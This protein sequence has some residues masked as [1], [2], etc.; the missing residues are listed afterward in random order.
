MLRYSEHLSFGDQ[1]EPVFVA[2]N[3]LRPDAPG[4]G[5]VDD[6]IGLCQHAM[7]FESC[8]MRQIIGGIACHFSG[9]Q[10]GAPNMFGGPAQFK[11]NEIVETGLQTRHKTALLRLVNQVSSR[12]CREMGNGFDV[13]QDK[14]GPALFVQLGEQLGGPWPQGFEG[15]VIFIGQLV[16]Q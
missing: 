9:N 4:A 5:N 1:N 12:A 8:A 10:I 14:G 7:Q 2:A 6:E 13:R 15:G 16:T 11:G 3:G